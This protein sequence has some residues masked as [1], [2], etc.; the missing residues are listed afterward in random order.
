MISC[1]S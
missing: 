1:E